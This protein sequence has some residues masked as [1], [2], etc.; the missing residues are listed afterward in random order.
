MC[1]RTY[2][3]SI[4]TCRTY[5]KWTGHIR[6]STPGHLCVYVLGNIV[7]VL[8]HICPGQY[9]LGY[10][11]WKKHI[12]LG[13]HYFDMSWGYVLGDMFMICPVD[14]SWGICEYVLGNIFYMCWGVCPRNMSWT[15][16]VLS[17]CLAD[18]SCV[19]S[20]ERYVLVV[21]PEGYILLLCLDDNV[22]TTICWGICP[23]DM[24]WWYTLKDM[25]CYYVLTTM[26]W[27]LSPERYDLVV[28][29]EGYVLL[30]CLD[31]YVLG[32]YPGWYVLVV[33]PVYMSWSI[34]IDEY[35]VIL[36]QEYTVVATSS[37]IW[38]NWWLL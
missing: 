11:S 17:L 19:L 5:T 34:C 37:N 13:E 12:C 23:H 21:Y 20:P 15:C 9:V 26:S 33:C 10:M 29:P 36:V 32:V 22:L 18:I 16:Y 14:M 2:K 31:D 1:S 30:L 38:I 3:I 25:S 4:D 7:Y 35:V 27:P 6:E 8:E 28:Y 24:S